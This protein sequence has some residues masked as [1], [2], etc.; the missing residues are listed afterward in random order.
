VNKKIDESINVLVNKGLNEL[1]KARRETD[2][3][4]KRYFFQKLS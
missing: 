4:S 3:Q 1:M 2:K